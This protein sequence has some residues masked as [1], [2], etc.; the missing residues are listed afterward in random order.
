M[1]PPFF[2]SYA[3]NDALGQTFLED[4]FAEVNTRVRK[5]TGSTSDGFFDDKQL[6]AGELWSAE[7]VKALRAAPAL[8]CMY[9]PSY[10]KSRVCG[11]E[12]QVFLERRA[13]HIDRHTG[14]L[15]ANIIPVLWIPPLHRIPISLPEFQYA[16]PLSAEFRNAGV[17]DLRDSG[18]SEAILGEFRKIA[19]DVAMRVKE[20]FKAPLL[21][22]P[23]TPVLEGIDSAFGPPR[24]P[25]ED[26]DPVTV[27]SG[28]QHVTYA[29]P[30]G[31]AWSAWPFHPADDPILH[32]SAA[33]A[34]GRDLRPH[35][36]TFDPAD[37][38]LIDR[39]NDVRRKNNL[40]V[41]LLDGASL[42]DA[43]LRERL[44]EFDRERYEA[45]TMIVW[46][47]G[48]RTAALDRLIAEA[49]PNQSGRQPPFFQPDIDSPG[50]FA[51]AI[52][53]SLDGLRTAVS[54]QPYGIAPMSSTSEYAEVPLV[55]ASKRAA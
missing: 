55:D 6:R 19:K 17:W 12:M 16:R 10:F 49:L 5:L 3:H 20:A 2:F 43:A 50:L 1:T 45:A 41:M 37:S 15:P 22:L 24:L 46:R 8:V 42:T 35:Q 28:P 39:L 13:H 38:R 14:S 23:Y 29:Y 34:K 32:I 33:A 51:D 31:P 18:G 21:D 4:F 26:F 11:G 9:S 40:L 7:L 30:L 54:R 36:L 44:K 47:A 25:P 52:L 48:T 27:R 53:R